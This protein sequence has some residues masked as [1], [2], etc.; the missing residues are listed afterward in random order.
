MNRVQTVVVKAFAAVFTVL[1]AWVFLMAI[2]HTVLSDRYLPLALAP[3]LAALL[4]F[5]KKKLLPVYR[6]IPAAVLTRIFIGVSV[7]AWLLMLYFAYRTRLTYGV[8]TWDFS[9]VHIDAYDSAVDPEWLAP[10]Y[11]LQYKNNQFLLLVLSALCRIVLLFAPSA[12]P[13]AFHA[14]A[15]AVNCTVI[16]ASVLMSYFAARNVRGAH[17]AF[18]AGTMLLL[19]APLW[20]YA[21]IYYTDTMGL[22]A[23]TLPLLL[24]TAVRRDAPVRNCILL[25]V[26]G[27]VCG[28]GMMIK[29]SIVIVGIAI[30]LG[31]LL[32]HKFRGKWIGLLC[33]AVCVILTATVL[34]AGID[35]KY[36]FTEKQYDAWQFPYTH[37]M[38]MS[39]S[40]NGGYD[41]ELVRYTASF[42]TMA[43]RKEAVCEKTAEL[44]RERGPIGTLRHVF[45]TKM[46]RTWGDGTQ[47][48]AY[49]L[50]REP[51]EQGFFQRLF[52]QKGDR[53][54]WFWEWAQTYHLML[55]FFLVLAGIRLFRAPAGDLLTVMQ[56]AIFG[57]LLFLLVWESN[58]RYLLHLSPLIVL[59]AAHGLA[60]PGQRLSQ[61]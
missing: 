44:L 50:G 9:R 23:V 51:A 16:M 15:M 4:L 54:L 39:L 27:I 7:A 43:E 40:K 31:I 47:S 1:F 25:A 21:A 49:Y 42:D 5:V 22:W 52:N 34:Q 20:L 46:H 8:D 11:Y 58:S 26:I 12:G 45:V 56:I 48:G 17:F 60:G 2:A 36:G 38:M 33:A 37:W 6:R 35:R 55:L 29:M 19:Y 61:K 3:I 13:L 24:Y 28:V 53:Y 32:F 10:H 57:L 41:A 14:A 59:C 30:G 18:V